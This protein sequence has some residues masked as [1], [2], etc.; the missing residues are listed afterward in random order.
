LILQAADGTRR[1]SGFGEYLLALFDAGELEIGGAEDASREVIC[2]FLE[3]T[4][5]EYLDFL[6]KNALILKMPGEIR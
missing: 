5:G 2:G 6:V 3:R 1:K 4:A